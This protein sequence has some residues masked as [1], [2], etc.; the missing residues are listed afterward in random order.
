MNI[1]FQY[2]SI[3][4]DKEKKAVIRLILMIFRYKIDNDFLSITINSHRLLL[5]LLIEKLFFL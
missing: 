2:R 5:I 1:D 3:E 4:I